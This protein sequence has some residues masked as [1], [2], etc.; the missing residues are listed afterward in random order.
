MGRTLKL[1]AADS[2]SHAVKVS[3]EKYVRII[4]RTASLMIASP[5]CITK[6]GSVAQ[7]MPPTEVSRACMQKTLQRATLPRT[8]SACRNR[9]YCQ[10]RIR[11]FEVASPN[12]PKEYPNNVGLESEG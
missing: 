8:R 1:L 5:S 6:T 10:N 11:Q 2:T 4:K 9:M 12:H 7:K 3:K